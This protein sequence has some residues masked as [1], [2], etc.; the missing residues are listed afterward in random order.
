[1]VKPI[2]GRVGCGV[3]SSY[4]GIINLISEADRVLLLLDYDG[5]LTPIVEMPEEAVLSSSMKELLKALS[6]REKIDVCIMSGRRL[7]D[8]KN[9]VGIPN[10]IYVG[11]HGLEVSEREYKVPGVQ[12][13]ELR[14]LIKKICNE[15]S[16][17]LADME[18]VLIE[19]KGL[20]A[21][22][23]YRRVRENR[24]DLLKKIVE[25]VVIPYSPKIR[26]TKGEKV[27]EIRPNIQW[28]KGKMADLI[29]GRISEEYP[30]ENLLPVYIGD[31]ATDEDAF[32]ALE[33]KGI[34]IL[35]SDVAKETKAK[36]RLESIEETEKLLRTVNS[37]FK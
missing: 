3:I 20:T 33:E 8:I 37:I 27:L 9:L 19:N 1:M 23:H 4:S 24:V 12:A 7:G 15:C 29:V 28:D 35:V 5:T 25:G 18:G 36:F 17:L 32:E 31:D 30:A 21:S 34:T 11:N 22:I 14:P 16:N 6:Q 10:V 2:F 26:L 13:G